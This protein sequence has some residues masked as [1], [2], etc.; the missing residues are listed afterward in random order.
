MIHNNVAGVCGHAAASCIRLL[1]L[2]DA[3]KWLPLPPVYDAGEKIAM[4][5]AAECRRIQYRSV[6]PMAVN[7]QG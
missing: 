7:E 4:S 2:P 3:I 1:R 6:L 5:Q